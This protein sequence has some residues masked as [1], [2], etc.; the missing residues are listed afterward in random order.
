VRREMRKLRLFAIAGIWLCLIGA[1]NLAQGQAGSL[2][3]TFG[4]NGEVISNFSS[5]IFV[6]DAVL[7]ANNKILVAMSNNQTNFAVVRYQTNGAL[8]T[9]FGSGGVAQTTIGTTNL[10]Q[11]IALQSNG[12]IVV[13]G[14]ANNKFAV[15]RFNTDGTLDKKFGG[16]GQGMGWATAPVTGLLNGDVVLIQPNGSI[17]V[18]GLALQS[19]RRCSPQLAMARFTSSGSLDTTFGNQGTTQVI[20][21]MNPTLL[22]L[23]TSNDILVVGL[24]STIQEFDPSGNPM[25]AVTP[26]PIGNTSVGG[27]AAFVPQSS[28]YYVDESVADGPVNLRDTDAQLLQFLGTGSAD[29]AFNSPLLD[30]SGTGASTGDDAKAI[31]LTQPTSSASQIMVGVSHFNAGFTNE[32]FGLARVNADGSLDSAFGSGGQVTTS[33]GGVEGL[34]AVL[35][36]TDGK[37]VA[38]GTANNF[39]DVALVRYLGGT[40]PLTI[41]ASVSPANSNNWINSNVTISYVCMGGVAPVQCPGQQVVS[42]EGANQSITATATDAVGQKATVTRTISID[43]TPPTIQATVT[44]SPDASGNVILPASGAVTISFTCTDPNNGNGTAGSGIATCPTTISVTTLGLGQSFSGTAVDRAGNSATANVT[45]NVLGMQQLAGDNFNRANASNL[46]PNWT[47]MDDNFTTVTPSPQIVSGQVEAQMIDQGHVSKAMYYGGLNWPVNQYSE[48]QLVSVGASSGN[49]GAAVRMTT[50]NSHYACV[51]FAV[52]NGSASI[53]ILKFNKGTQTDLVT[54]TA[55]TVALSDVV[56]CAVSG[57][58][59]TMTDQTTSTTLLTATDATIPA[60]Y[61]GIVI[62]TN[63]QL[64]TYALGHWAGG[65]DSAPLARQTLVT[66]NFNR[67]DAPSLGPNWTG[68]PS[69]NRCLI[70]IAGQTVKPGTTPASCGYPAKE[71]YTASAF[72]SDQWGQV[73]IVAATGTVDNGVE[74]RFQAAQDTHYLC[75][76][77]NTGAAGTAEVRLVEVVSGS[78]TTL[79]IASTQVAFTAGDFMLGQ[80]QGALLSCIDATQGTLLLTMNDTTITGGA[81]GLSMDQISSSTVP[82][83]TNWSAGGFH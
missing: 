20:S 13:A 14:V 18:A 42:S 67:P 40:P 7:D 5:P 77:N 43:K 80:V 75:D 82:Q 62:F 47:T 41:T 50:D 37:I 24:D 48:I 70:A 26:A 66:D 35:V 60:G 1:V 4:S 10:V 54:S 29:T 56:R 28:N 36:Q 8:D 15:A 12:Q 32:L 72:P 76:V 22:A 30:F 45:L 44:P 57:T 81:P 68:S 27:P 11:S 63:V 3:T 6:G 2:D 61:P 51:V 9:T 59:I 23:N 31:A 16:N 49:V 17:L 52:G 46:G 21:S 33:V 64:N 55:A 73:Q 58:T 34:A 74:L 78:P 39:T 83:A 79:S 69:D 65:A 25:S 19:C 38:I 53:E 71:H